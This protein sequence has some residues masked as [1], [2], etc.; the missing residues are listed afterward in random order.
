[1]PSASAARSHSAPSSRASRRQ[2]TWR[3]STSCDEAEAYASRRLQR[4]PP[5]PPRR[6]AFVG[7]ARREY[8]RLVERAA[9]ELEA[10][11]E[12][13]A[14]EA[15]T[16]RRRRLAG[17]VE[18]HGERGLAEE[19]EDRLRLLELFRRAPVVGC[20]DEVVTAHR[21]SGVE[22]ELAA[23]AQ[24]G[25]VL[26]RRKEGPELEAPTRRV[27]ELFRR[28]DHLLAM[29]GVR[30]YRDDDTAADVIIPDVGEGD[31]VDRRA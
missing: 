29:D 4:R 23:E 26:L 31:L 16:D 2:R 8:A 10:E 6:G 9:G 14:A 5:L 12:A 11:R 25:D 15:A 7:G 1:M 13:V 24:R 30:L 19:V 27:A 28:L 18:R 21:R 17:D 22:R 20:H 3:P